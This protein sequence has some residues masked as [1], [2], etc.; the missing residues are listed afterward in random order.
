MHLYFLL[1]LMCAIGQK[2]DWTDK[3]YFEPL[4]KHIEGWYEKICNIKDEDY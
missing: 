3:S 1:A 2:C 4:L